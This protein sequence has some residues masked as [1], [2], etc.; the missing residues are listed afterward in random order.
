MRKNYGGLAVLLLLI[1]SASLTIC[2]FLSLTPIPSNDEKY[3]EEY[4]KSSEDNGS[5]LDVPNAPLNKIDFQPIVD[6]WV[7][8]TGGNKGIYIYDLD[9]GE[10]VGS[11]NSNIEFQTASIYKLFVVYEGYKRLDSGEWEPDDMAG[12]TGHTISKCLDLAIRESNSECAETIWEKI[13]IEKM[14]YIIDN[15]FHLKNTEL[16]DLVSTPYDVAEMMKIVY[17]HEDIN[18]AEY[19]AQLKDSFLNQPA[20][21]YDWR[22]GLPSGFETAKVYNKVGWDYDDRMGRWNIYNDAAIVEFPEQNRHYVVVVMTNNVQHQQ[23]RK[24]G[25]MLEEKFF[26]MY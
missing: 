25:Q 4:I 16:E 22:Q 17:H 26:S 19:L 2:L 13:G 18:S 8:S 14:Q 10:E 6:E 21:I 7:S 1:L 20:R 12:A 11:Y 9:L 24:L 15:N 23:I 3:S 5:D